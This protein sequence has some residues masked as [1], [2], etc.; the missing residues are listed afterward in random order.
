MLVERNVNK[1]FAPLEHLS[2]E[3]LGRARKVGSIALVGSR[4][5]DDFMK[6]KRVPR[7]SNGERESD[8]ERS[9]TLAIIAPEIARVLGLDLDHEKI[10]KFA[11]VHDLIEVKVGDVSSFNLTPEQLTEKEHRE[12]LAK[13][14]LV[15]ELEPF[16][17]GLAADLVAYENQDTPEAIFVRT[18]DKLQPLAV[19]ITGDGLRVIRE[20]HGI[21]TLATLYTAHERLQLNLQERFGEYFPDVV[22]AHAVLVET[23]AQKYVETKDEIVSDAA[24]ERGPVEVE[25]KFVIDLDQNELNEIIA[26]AEARSN[27]RQGYVAIGTDGSETRVRSLDDER[28]SMTVKTVGDISRGEQ[29]IDISREMFS[30]LWET[31]IGQRVEKVRYYIPYDAYTIELDVYAADLA[32]LVTAEVEFSAGG[33]READAL[34]RAATFT[35]PEWFGEDVTSDKRYKNQSLARFG[36]P[37]AQLLP[38]ATGV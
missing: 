3:A 4:L 37:V 31:T 27:I 8:V 12:Q 22:N 17:P 11:L 33:K 15:R 23:L 7:L 25:R 2:P 28:F 19:D 26:S 5:T 29:N 16:M 10:T 6:I 32:G 18:V 21:D 38:T 1:L 14:E 35:P 34:V 36:A 24:T 20:D 30:A 13:A 9:F